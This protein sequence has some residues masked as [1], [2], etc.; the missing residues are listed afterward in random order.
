MMSVTFHHYGASVVNASIAQ[1][2]RDM[3]AMLNVPAD[4]VRAAGRAANAAASASSEQGR[5]FVQ[6]AIQLGAT[7]FLEEAIDGVAG[8]HTLT[9]RSTTCAPEIAEYVA[10]CT[11]QR[12]EDAPHMTFVEWMRAYRPAARADNDQIRPFVSSLLDQDQAI[13]SRLAAEYGS[14]EVLCIDYTLGG[15]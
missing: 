4:L 5:P 8:K 1:L 12:L 7:A 6:L 10:T 3:H 15:A 9:Y 14:P 13:T 11:L 2:R